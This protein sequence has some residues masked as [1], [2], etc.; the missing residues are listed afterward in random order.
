LGVPLPFFMAWVVGLVELLGSLAL[1]LGLWVRLAAILLGVEMLVAFLLT[2]SGGAPG[3]LAP[4][5]ALGAMITL[6][7]TGA[8]ALSL[9]KRLV[10]KAP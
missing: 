3:Y 6:L 2:L 4:F 8:G 10:K 7:F 9:G 1:I 5:F